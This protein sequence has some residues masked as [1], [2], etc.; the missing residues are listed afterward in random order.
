MLKEV[1]GTEEKQH[2]MEIFMYTKSKETPYIYG[3]EHQV[4][5]WLN[6]NQ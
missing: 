4:Y 5:V 1:F 3:K 2:Q 6:T